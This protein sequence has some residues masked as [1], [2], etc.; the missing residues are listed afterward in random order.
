MRNIL[1]V[2]DEV[3]LRG[4]LGDALEEDGWQVT[5]AESGDEAL[6]L[7]QTTG[8]FDAL[9]TDVR[10]PGKADGLDL[11]R[12]ARC[13]CSQMNVVVMSGYTGWA[14][15]TVA[16]EGLGSFIAKPFVFAQLKRLLGSAL[17]PRALSQ[18]AP[19]VG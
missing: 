19:D 2:D 10:M 4:A 17:Y 7:L 3:G 13:W 18:R 9:L 5:Q 14:G 15:D 8:R 6:E 16:A 12:Y 1:V 11:A